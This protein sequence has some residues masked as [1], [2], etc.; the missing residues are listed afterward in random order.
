[1]MSNGNAVV[2]YDLTGGTARFYWQSNLVLKGFYAGV[3]LSSYITGNAYST[4]TWSGLGSTGAV[5]TSTSATLPTMK[6]FFTF[7]D[8]NSF[9]TRMEVDGTN[10]SATWMG[11]VVV[12]T[13]G[14]V[15]LG[16]YNGDRALYVPFDND[17]FVTYNAMPLN[18]SATGY[19]VAA[20]YDNTTRAGLVVGSVTHDTWKSGVY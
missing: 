14:G 20:F 4:H 10:L 2:Q 12:S 17:H 11:P 7:F 16:S 3:Q 19:E 15:D 8:T 13:N 1:M 5:V 18:S 9:L 6:Q